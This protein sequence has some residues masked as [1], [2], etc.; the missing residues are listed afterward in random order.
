MPIPQLYLRQENS[1]TLRRYLESVVLKVV[2]H[3]KPAFEPIVNGWN[4]Y[5]K[6]IAWYKKDQSSHDFKYSKPDLTDQ[7]KLLEIIKKIDD[8][9]AEVEKTSLLEARPLFAAL[10][11]FKSCILRDLNNY[12]DALNNCEIARSCLDIDSKKSSSAIIYSNKA[13]IYN[14]KSDYAKGVEN[15]TKAYNLIETQLRNADQE[16]EATRNIMGCVVNIQGYSLRK[17][18]TND[19]DAVNAAETQRLAH[20]LYPG[21]NVVRNNLAITLTKAADEGC[22]QE[23]IQLL[24]PQLQLDMAAGRYLFVTPYYL[25]DAYTRL[26]FLQLRNAPDIN[27]GLI[28]KAQMALDR[29]AESLTKNK[30]YEGTYQ[31]KGEARVARLQ[32]VINRLLKNMEKAET[33]ATNS[34][35]LMLT[36]LGKDHPKLAYFNNKVDAS[37]TAEAPTLFFNSVPS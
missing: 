32:G 21:S 37:V 1:E 25:A 36:A 2:D 3:N 31:Q 35:A 26:A 9:I 17:T 10:Y 33:C 12:D 23:A 19:I 5:I 8:I 4:N 7:E 34:K 13:G 18:K 30:S 6:L 24:E 11:N 22:Q 20:R 29:A 28:K 16:D 15:S 27:Q 14:A